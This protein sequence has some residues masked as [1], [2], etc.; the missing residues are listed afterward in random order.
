MSKIPVILLANEDL[1][2]LRRFGRLRCSVDAIVEGDTLIDGEMWI[3]IVDGKKAT[4]WAR[5]PK[6]VKG[7]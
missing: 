2:N 7:L 5:L 3:V 4:D 1:E 6:T